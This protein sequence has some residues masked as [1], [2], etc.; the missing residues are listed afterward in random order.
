MSAGFGSSLLRATT[1]SVAETYSN[2]LPTIL[3][4]T[5]L[6]EEITSCEQATL[7][8]SSK[9]ACAGPLSVLLGMSITIQPLEACNEGRIQLLCSA[10]RELLRDITK[11]PYASHAAAV[12]S[13][14]TCRR[15]WQHWYTHLILNSFVLPPSMCC[16]ERSV[17][18]FDGVTL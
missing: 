2:T 18:S 15:F 16:L 4:G 7:W 9:L 10:G 1:R 6:L 8:N 11:H 13:H 17:Y 5:M 14:L 3:S 12:C